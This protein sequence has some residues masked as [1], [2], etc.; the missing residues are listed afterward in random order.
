MQAPE[1]QV[2]PAMPPSPLL[3]ERR[4]PLD[5]TVTLPEIRELYDNGKAGRWN[6]HR[7]IDWSQLAPGTI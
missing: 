3:V 6:P 5:M 1:H 2:S 4:F 7:D